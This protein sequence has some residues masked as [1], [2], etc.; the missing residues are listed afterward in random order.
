MPAG[1]SGWFGS[2]QCPPLLL[3]L[4]S[5]EADFRT[6]HPLRG[7]FFVTLTEAR[8]VELPCAPAVCRG[9]AAAR[10]SAARLLIGRLALPALDLPDTGPVV[11]PGRVHSLGRFK[12]DGLHK[13]LADAL[14]AALRNS[15]RTGFEWYACRGAFFHNDAH[16]GT[17]LFGAWC[18][19][20]PPREIVFARAG[21]RV[22]A[23]P[24]DWVIFDPFEP[25]AV[26]D[27]GTD[28]RYTREHYAGAPAS[29]FVGFELHLDERVVDAFAI[30]PAHPD[31]PVLASSVAIHAETGALC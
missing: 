28:D 30:T 31:A 12:R 21:T 6:P 13:A 29:L 7:S 27:P 25:H 4:S 16:Y 23:G 17:V 22:P 1:S 19:A 10:G 14:P 3:P 8:F 15:L 20:G 24:G 2:L 26:L 11:V 9:P 18:V 5:E